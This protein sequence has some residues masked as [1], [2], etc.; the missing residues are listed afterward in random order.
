M[1]CLRR[2]PRQ[3][4]EDFVKPSLGGVTGYA[5]E[6]G[7]EFSNAPEYPPH[8]TDDQ[9][10]PLRPSCCAMCAAESKRLNDAFLRTILNPLA[11]TGRDLDRE[12]EIE[13]QEDYEVTPTQSGSGG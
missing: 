7:A 13:N 6:P 4:M 1:S 8:A 5:R 11:P 3:N 2:T 9:G 12:E 10:F